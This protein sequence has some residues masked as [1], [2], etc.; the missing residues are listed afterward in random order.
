MIKNMI[1]AMNKELN[2]DEYKQQIAD[3]YSGRSDKYDEGDW[4]PRIAHRLV[5]HTHI[6]RGK[7]VLDIATGTGMVAIEAAQIVGAE[8]RVVGV[9]ISTGMLDQGRR[10]VE[11]LGLKNI[12]F[13]LGDAEVLNFPANSFD[14]VLCSSALIWMVDIPGALHLWMRFLK[15]GGLIGF[16]A[17]AETAFVGRVSASQTLLTRGF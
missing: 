5:E 11:V 17:F 15:P 8:G 9:D 2:L 7:Y 3:L 12:E 10:K 1:N 13:Q 4:H 14:V 16:H 6:N